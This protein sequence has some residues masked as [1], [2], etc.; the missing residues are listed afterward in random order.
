MLTALLA[1]FAWYTEKSYEQSQS[2]SPFNSRFVPGHDPDHQSRTT[3]AFQLLRPR[4]PRWRSR[5]RRNAGHSLGGWHLCGRIA[6]LR[7]QGQLSRIPAEQSAQWDFG[8][9]RRLDLVASQAS[10]VPTNV[11]F[12]LSLERRDTMLNPEPVPLGPSGTYTI[13]TTFHNIGTAALTDLY[14]EVIELTGGN[15]LLN[16]DDEPGDVGAILSVPAGALS[17]DGV[18]SPDESFDL[19]F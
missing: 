12:L 18:L 17:E 2:T 10:D 7:C 8:T 5:I 3:A 14:F 4:H 19:D 13:S 6:Y 1:S 9:Y 16:A 11:N 15:I